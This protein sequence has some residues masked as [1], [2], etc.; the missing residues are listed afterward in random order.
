MAEVVNQEEISAET[1]IGKFRARGS[2]ILGVGQIVILCMVAYGGYIHTVDA[3]DDNREQINAIKANTQA[4]R[5]Q[6]AE[7][8]VQNCWNMLS[9]E[10]KK[11]QRMSEF[12]KSL[13]ERFPR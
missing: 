9:S 10:Q 13:G 11:D 12:C 1:P 6:V 8:R 7:M 5:E 3:K 2:D 4:Q